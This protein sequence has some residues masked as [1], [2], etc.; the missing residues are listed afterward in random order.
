MGYNLLTKWPRP[1]KWGY[2]HTPQDPPGGGS[3]VV[4]V[5]VVFFVIGPLVDR[6]PKSTARTA[7]PH[8]IEGV[9]P[10]PGA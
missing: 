8:P 10:R 3:M 2:L 7:P 1:S 6:D 5:V 4:V 9:T